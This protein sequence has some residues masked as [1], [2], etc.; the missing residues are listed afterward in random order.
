MNYNIIVPARIGFGASYLFGKKG[1]ISFD[2]N[3]QD[4]SKAR[5]K[6][7][8]GGY[9]NSNA[10]DFTFNNENLVRYL[11]PTNQ[12]KIGGELKIERLS[13]RAGFGY[14]DS[15]Y[16]ASE[17]LKA[18]SATTIS[19]GIGY[20]FDSVSIDFGLANTRFIDD[21]FPIGRDAAAVTNSLTSGNVTVIFR[22]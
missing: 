21:Y 13:L 6:N 19:A 7:Q 8:T 20:N 5:F 17:R 9:S 2:Y 14:Q 4:F 18:T 16:K 10:Y 15:P 1:L 12:L 11:G 3:R 22:Y